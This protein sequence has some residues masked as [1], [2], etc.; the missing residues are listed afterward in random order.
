MEGLTQGQPYQ[1]EEA[2]ACSPCRWRSKATPP[3]KQM[4][5]APCKPATAPARTATTP[6]CLP[7]APLAPHRPPAVGCLPPPLAAAPHTA[8]PPHTAPAPPRSPP[9]R[10]DTPAASP[11]D[12]AAPGTPAS[13]PP[14]NAARLP[15]G[16]T[17]PR[18]PPR[19]HRAHSSALCAPAPPHSLAPP[20]PLP[21]TPRPAPR[22][23]PAPFARPAHTAAG[24]PAVAQ[25]AYS[26]PLAHPPA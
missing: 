23:A 20:Q 7:L 5:Q 17:S 8:A 9:T 24:S 6:G 18:L 21:R 25:S 15:F 22:W 2:H 26:P 1:G 16:T 14:G 4:P 3:G 10:C 13:H 19:T 11:A 12:P